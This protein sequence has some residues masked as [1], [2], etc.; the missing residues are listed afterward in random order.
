MKNGSI[1]DSFGKRITIKVLFTF[2]KEDFCLLPG[3]KHS[4]SFHEKVLLVG[5]FRICIIVL[6]VVDSGLHVCFP[7]KEILRIQ[8]KL[9]IAYKRVDESD[10]IAFPVLNEPPAF[11]RKHHF[12]FLKI[13][14]RGIHNLCSPVKCAVYRLQYRQTLNCSTSI[15]LRLLFSCGQITI[16][17]LHAA[18]K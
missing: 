5:N 12:I 3:N 8:I 13:P 10:Y 1:Y 16:D 4:L 18:F 2:F 17:Y 7:V 11:Q 6:L 14:F 15:I 9:F